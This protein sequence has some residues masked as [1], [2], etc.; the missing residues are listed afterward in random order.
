MSEVK[1]TLLTIVLVLAVFATVYAAMTFA[2]KKEAD[3][4]VQKIDNPSYTTQTYVPP[5]N[6]EA[7]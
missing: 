4:I 7:S 2:F 1:G 5:T 3:N 6:G